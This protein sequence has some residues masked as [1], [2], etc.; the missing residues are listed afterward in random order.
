MCNLII[1]WWLQE[2]F[3]IVRGS[4]SGSS[5]DGACIGTGHRGNGRTTVGG[6][7]GD[8]TACCFLYFIEFVNKLKQNDKNQ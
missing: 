5:G 1:T 2:I 4:A 7:F 3:K 6:H 8:G